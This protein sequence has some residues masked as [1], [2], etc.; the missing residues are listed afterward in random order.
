MQIFYSFSTV[1]WALT[2]NLSIVLPEAYY[3]VGVQPLGRTAW[4]QPRLAMPP[5]RPRP[6]WSC[7]QPSRAASPW[8]R[9]PV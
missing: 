9:L 3:L 8:P 5:T 1:W 6:V 2:V 4:P 7:R